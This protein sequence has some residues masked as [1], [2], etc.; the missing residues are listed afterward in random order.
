[1]K[2]QP[3]PFTAARPK[4][5]FSPV[6]VKLA[7]DS[8]ISGGSREMPHSLHSAMY[9]ATFSL[10]SSTEVRRAAIYSLV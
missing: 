5:I 3:T 6:T 7:P 9:S 2:P 8:L 4:R 10:E 1:M